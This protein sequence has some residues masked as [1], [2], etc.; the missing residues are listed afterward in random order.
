M[1]GSSMRTENMG[2]TVREKPKGSGRW[3]LFYNKGGRTREMPGFTFKTK[4][5]AEETAEKLR[6]RLSLGLT[7]QDLSKDAPPL[8]L[9]AFNWL[10][11]IEKE[12]AVKANSLIAAY[13]PAVRLHIAPFFGSRPINEIKPADVRAFWASIIEKG[14]SEKTARNVI[15]FTSLILFSSRNIKRPCYGLIFL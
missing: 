11:R 15:I 7:I 10:D 2:I 3:R 12:R 13:E 4:K 9:Y 6:A 1:A 8:N 5:A 14:L